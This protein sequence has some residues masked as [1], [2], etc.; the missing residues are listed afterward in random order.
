MAETKSGVQSESPP[1][2]ENNDELDEGLS[3]IRVAAVGSAL[4]KDSGQFVVVYLTH[5]VFSHNLIVSC[6]GD[7]WFLYNTGS[8]LLRCW[9]NAVGKCFLLFR[10]DVDNVSWVDFRSL[11]PVCDMSCNETHTSYSSVSALVKFVQA[12]FQIQL[13]TS[14]L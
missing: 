11:A 8:Y 3:P 13:E 10:H 7:D 1:E 5:I 12:I 6:S 14:S 9:R 2:A 4:G